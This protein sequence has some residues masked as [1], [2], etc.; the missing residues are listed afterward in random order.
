LAQEGITQ[1]QWGDRK[2]FSPKNISLVRNHAERVS[3]GVETASE[4]TIRQM[5]ASLGVK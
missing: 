1:K 5:A 2:G 4:A 3:R